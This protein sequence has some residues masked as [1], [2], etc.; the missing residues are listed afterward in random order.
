SSARSSASRGPG[1]RSAP[2]G[3]GRASW[4]PRVHE[5]MEARELSF[6]QA[7]PRFRNLAESTRGSQVESADQV[8]QLI[9]DLPTLDLNTDGQGSRLQI[10]NGPRFEFQDKASSGMIAGAYP[11]SLQ[12][13]GPPCTLSASTAWPCCFSSFSL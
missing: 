11:F 8:N 3:A 1:S 13:R 12:L 10:S 2:A 9:N 4:Y 7:A 6:R 5:V